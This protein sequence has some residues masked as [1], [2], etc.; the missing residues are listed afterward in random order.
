MLRHN[1]QSVCMALFLCMAGLAACDSDDD[2]DNNGAEAGR[3]S[4]AGSGGK[5]GAGGKGDSSQGGKGGSGGESSEGGSGGSGDGPDGC[6]DG[7]AKEDAQ[8]LNHC[9][10]SECEPFDNAARLPLFKDGK[11]PALP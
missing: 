4:R 10:D 3:V 2:A 11:L 7:T 6:Y 5:G 8:F 9:T 1:K